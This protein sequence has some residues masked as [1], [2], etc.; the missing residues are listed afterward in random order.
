MKKLEL[1]Y[2][3]TITVKG[4]TYHYFRKGTTRVRLKAAP[5]TDAFLRE[6]WQLRSG[7]TSRASQTNWD[8]LITRPC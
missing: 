2:L 1:P 4:R 6:Y 7:Q 3:D 5:G 8:R